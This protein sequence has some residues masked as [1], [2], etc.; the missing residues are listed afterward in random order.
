[1]SLKPD[2]VGAGS[3]CLASGQTGGA[4]GN[5]DLG[6]NPLSLLHEGNLDPTIIGL[7]SGLQPLEVAHLRLDLKLLITR[8]QGINSSQLANH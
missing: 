8:L 3:E 6:L 7:E 1:M 5:R 2:Y 4:F